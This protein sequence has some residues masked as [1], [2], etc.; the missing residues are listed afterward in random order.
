M[1]AETTNAHSNLSQTAPCIAK[2]FTELEQGRPIL[3]NQST[4][5]QTNHQS[6]STLQK[7]KIKKKEIE[8]DED[9][10]QN[11]AKEKREK[12][13]ANKHARVKAMEFQIF[14]ESARR[15]EDVK[16]FVRLG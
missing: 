8:P 5:K 6:R 15:L 12:N 2:S 4:T 9:I 7:K 11:F 3:S 14:L 10:P 13:N 1:E 16:R